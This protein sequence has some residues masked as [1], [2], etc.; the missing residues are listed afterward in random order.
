MLS[1][2]EFPMMKKLITVFIALLVGLISACQRITFGVIRDQ[3]IALSSNWLSVSLSRPVTAKWDVQA[4]Y[5]GV[6]SKH[7]SSTDPLGIRLEDGSIVKPEIELVTKTG[8]VQPFRFVG[9][10]N[11]DLVFENDHIAR[12]SS[13]AELRIRSPKPVVCSR[14]SWISYM[15]QDTKTGVP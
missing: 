8:E 4:I 2:T 14:I 1:V 5:V 15:P 6:G 9:F 7:Q 13:F 10:S 12:G 3:P 11:A